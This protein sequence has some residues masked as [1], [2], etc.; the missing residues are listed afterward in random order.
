MDKDTLPFIPVP[1]MTVIPGRTPKQK[2]HKRISDAKN[3]FDTTKYNRIS[4]NRPDN[5]ITE[6]QEQTHGWGQL[7]EFKDGEWV[8]LYEVPQPTADNITLSRVYPWG[9]T[10]CAETRPWKLDK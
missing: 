3:A 9:N 8:L 10:Y 1:Y 2:V 5:G 6:H 4:Y 7:Y